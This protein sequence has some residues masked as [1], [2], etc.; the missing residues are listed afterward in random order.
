MFK[1]RGNRNIRRQRHSSD[2]EEETNGAT[3]ES[4]VPNLQNSETTTNKPLASFFTPSQ[5]TS[6]KKSL[7]KPASAA[8]LSFDHEEEGCCCY[9]EIVVAIGE[10]EWIV[11]EEDGIA[12]FKLKKSSSSRR[13]NRLRKQ[14]KLPGDS[15][16]SEAATTQSDAKPHTNTLTGKSQSPDSA[17]T[18]SSAAVSSKLVLRPS[19]N[20]T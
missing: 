13:L 19:N 16:E 10:T 7:P 12:T 20:S 1:K 8:L 14:G 17:S 4:A 15:N 6:P 2:E 3:E 11:S 18:S 5:E 9:V